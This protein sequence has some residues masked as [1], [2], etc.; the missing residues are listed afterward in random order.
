MD[1]FQYK[2]GDLYCEGIRLAE[3]ADRFGT[4]SYIYSQATLLRHCRRLLKAFDSYPTTACFAVKSNSNLSVLRT[5]FSE[6]FGADLVSAGELE[7]SLQAGV[8]PSRIV[9]SGVGKLDQE[10]VAGLNANILSFNVESDFELHAIARLARE[11]GK[12]AR[13]SLRINPNIDAR[14]NEK[15]ATGLYST[16]FGIPETEL[17]AHLQIIKDSPSLKL[18]GVACHIGSQI[19]DLAPLRDAATRMA[20]VAKNVVAAGFQL[21]LVDMGGGLGIRYSSESTPELEDYASTLIG[22][23]KPTGLRLVIEPGRVLVGNIGILLSRVIGVK[24]TPQKNFIILDAAMND[25]MRPTLYGSYHDIVP[26]NEYPGATDPQLCDFVGPVC[27]TGDYLGKDRR[28]PVPK[29]GDLFAVRGC[30]AYAAIMASNYNSRGIA[31]EIM[32]EGDEAKVIRRRQK[33]AEI[34]QYEEFPSS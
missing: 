16:K 27:E 33:P 18:V 8:T 3:L 7:R 4:P 28:C 1:F 32:V 12:V 2:S 34:W 21:E 13:V 6:G 10:I 14:T 25:L 24:R 15:I 9:F 11:A 5:I 29:A 17:A 19:T 22:A 26:V 23:I 20:Q 31:P 30:G